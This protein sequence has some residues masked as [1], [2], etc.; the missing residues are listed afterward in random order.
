MVLYYLQVLHTFH[1]YIIIIIITLGAFISGLIFPIISDR[2]GRKYALNLAIVIGG[3]SMFFAGF[4]PNF[5][6]F[7]VLLFFAGFGLF[8][9]ETLTLVC[10]NEISGKY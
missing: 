9:F 4:S 1:Q 6:V 5:T 8:G 10:I 7:L 3:L 2:K